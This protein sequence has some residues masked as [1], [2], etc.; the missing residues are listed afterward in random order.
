MKRRGLEG[1]IG[2]LSRKRGGMSGKMV[3]YQ[4]EL[5]HNVID[6]HFF[7]QVH[8]TYSSFRLSIELTSNEAMGE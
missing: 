6:A 2:V 3:S 8:G 4:I 1:G 7:G 5:H